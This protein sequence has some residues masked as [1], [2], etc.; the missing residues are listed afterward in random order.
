MRPEN[1]D[2][3]HLA[4][5]LMAAKRIEELAQ[6]C[7]LDAYQQDWIIQAALERQMEIIGE[8]AR[9]VST[10]C[11]NKNSHIPWR[12]IIAQRNVLAHEYDD[13]NHRR[14]WEV[15]TQHIPQLIK[16][17]QPLVDSSSTNL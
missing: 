6:S 10:A 2:P 1:R 15:A 9:R 17:L 11:Q 7:N 4:D 8:A 5:M 12:L 3:A 14:I 13:I 16:Q